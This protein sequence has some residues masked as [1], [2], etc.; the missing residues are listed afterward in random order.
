MPKAG[1]VRFGRAVGDNGES[2]WLPASW[3]DNLLH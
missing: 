3:R 2:E 1:M